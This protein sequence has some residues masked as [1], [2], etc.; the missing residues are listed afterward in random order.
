MR[1]ALASLHMWEE[2]PISGINGSGTVFFTGCNL[3]CV[4][5]QNFEISQQSKGKEISEDDLINIF[6]ALKEKGAHNINL[7]SGGHFLNNIARAVKKAKEMEIGIP[8]VYNTNSYEKTE[9]LK[10]L[11]GLIDIYLPDIKYFD[12]YYSLKYSGAEDYFK[13]ASKA[14]LEMHRQTGENVFGEDGLLKK[15]III[16]HL[17]LPGLRHDSFKILEWINENLPDSVCISILNQYTPMYKASQIK[18]ISRRLTSFEYESVIDRFI[19]LG[20]KNGYMQKKSSQ[21]DC[22]TPDF[23]LDI[24]I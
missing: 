20:F 13:T 22:Y 2:P 8:F 19:E 9:S 6:F 5:C 3:K 17:V 10:L 15:G 18:E 4:F 16:R 24:M 14:V 21:S 12:P 7:V 23:N 11:E 1:V